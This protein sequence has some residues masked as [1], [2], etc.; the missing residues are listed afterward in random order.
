M[1]T[2]R[3]QSASAGCDFFSSFCDWAGCGSWCARADNTRSAACCGP[4][5]SSLNP[6]P[7]AKLN[8]PVPHVEELSEEIGGLAD[9]VVADGAGPL[10]AGPA[11]SFIDQRDPAEVLHEKAAKATALLAPVCDGVPIEVV[12]SPTER[13]RQ[14]CRFGVA[15]L[16]TGAVGFYVDRTRPDVGGTA[17]S[18]P[19]LAASVSEGA[20]ADA[21]VINTFPIASAAVEASMQLLRAAL[22]S[23]ELGPHLTPGLCTVGIHGTKSGPPPADVVVSLF[24]DRPLDPERWC[25]TA[26]AL[27]ARCGFC[28]VVGR[29]KGARLVSGRDYVVETLRTAAGPAYTYRQTEGHFSNPNSHIAELTLDWLCHQSQVI[30]DECADSLGF[31]GDGS[32][33]KVHRTDLLE[34]FCGNGNH[35]MALAG[36]GAFRAVLGVEINSVLVAAAQHNIEANGMGGR[37]QI[38]RAPSAKFVTK[39]MKHSASTA[40]PRRGH[41]SP[42]RG[43]TGSPSGGEQVVDRGSADCPRASK[44]QE[45]LAPGS[46]T[47]IVAGE[48]FCFRTVL[49]DPPRAGLDDATRSHVRRCTCP[50]P[51]PNSYTYPPLGQTHTRFVSTTPLCPDAKWFARFTQESCVTDRHILYISCNPLALRRDIEGLAKTHRVTAAAIFDHFPRTPHLETAVH[52]A[53]RPCWHEPT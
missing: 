14:R 46:A 43:T 30:A 48:H 35:T 44:L 16:P 15:H 20:V 17:E 12:A 40:T 45:A 39:I 32:A 23:I 49:V 22:A 51:I 36:C 41:G 26:D 27:R 3:Q 38:L 25:A 42:G 4:G 34:M 47:H 21:Q 50:L 33:A 29:A 18:D 19:P 37:C 31:E 6:R 13:W 53:A 24:Y 9:K 7:M 28:G 52:L 10:K 11:V 2:E 1:R 5:L 8:E